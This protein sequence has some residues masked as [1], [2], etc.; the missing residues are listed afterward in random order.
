MVPVTQEQVGN[1]DASPTY[2]VS[3]DTAVGFPRF[4]QAAVGA[5]GPVGGQL[6]LGGS[7]AKQVGRRCVKQNG[8]DLYV[9]WITVYTFYYC[10]CFV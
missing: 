10:S 5:V 2:L 9:H 7:R 6:C 4:F 8:I 1:V 3:A